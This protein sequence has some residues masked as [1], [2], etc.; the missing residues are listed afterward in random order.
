M[1]VPLWVLVGNGFWK[2]AEGLRKTGLGGSL[3]QGQGPGGLTKKKT[4][5]SVA[6]KRVWKARPQMGDQRCMGYWA[7]LRGLWLLAK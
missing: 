6:N 5:F 7:L 4:Y 3:V 2:Q 1:E